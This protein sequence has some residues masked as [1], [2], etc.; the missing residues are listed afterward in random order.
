ML[1]LKPWC[2][3]RQRFSVFRKAL[4]TNAVANSHEKNN[5]IEGLCRQISIVHDVR[6]ASKAIE[7]LLSLPDGTSVAWSAQALPPRKSPAMVTLCGYA[8]D[9]FQ[10][11]KWTF[12][13]P[14]PRHEAAVW[15]L[16]RE[17]FRDKAAKLICYDIDNFTKHLG[18]RGIQAKG[19][20][21]D[22]QTMIRM[23]CLKKR[24]FDAYVQNILDKR[25]I[26]K[27]ETMFS[28]QQERPWETP[29][30][31]MRFRSDEWISP[32]CADAH[33]VFH[34]YQRMKKKMLKKGALSAEANNLFEAYE[35]FYAHVDMSLSTIGN[36]MLFL[37]EDSFADVLMRFEY[38]R[39]SQQSI[40]ESW[41]QKYC[42]QVSHVEMT[43]PMLRHLLFAP[44]QNKH[45]MTENIEPE[46]NFSARQKVFGGH[47]TTSTV[48]RSRAKKRN[49]SIKG[50]GLVAQK[51]T[52]NGVPSVSIP[53]L[54]ALHATLD[55]AEDAELK[56]AFCAIKGLLNGQAARL[57]AQNF[58]K[59]VGQSVDIDRQ[60][61]PRTKVDF[62]RGRLQTNV[63][64][65]VLELLRSRKDYEV[66]VLDF[67]NL[68]LCALADFSGCER[69]KKR[70]HFKDGV[71]AYLAKEFSKEVSNALFDGKCVL[72]GEGVTV[73]KA[74]PDKFQ[75]AKMLDKCMS[76]APRIEIVKKVMKCDQARA[77]QLVDGWFQVHPAVRS[78]CEQEE[79]RMRD[80]KVAETVR[81]RQ[82]ILKF[83][84]GKRSALAV[85]EG[86]TFAIEGSAGDFMMQSVLKLVESERI[87]A[88]AWQV[89]LADGDRI[90]MHGPRWSAEEVA[91]AAL[92][93]LASSNEG[94]PILESA[95]H[96]LRM[97]RGENFRALGRIS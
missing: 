96:Q 85:N 7:A 27:R 38:D 53:A 54:Q 2:C 3:F 51:Y 60:V 49:V 18:S 10:N 64:T 44:Y 71:H 82:R 83:G 89:M 74:F 48:K 88:L 50:A 57:A 84:G 93:T 77:L 95:L 70:L 75:M 14:P 15:G 45:D 56:A 61:W 46:K 19:C 31:E 40:F 25:T 4:A 97:L 16:M 59:E 47:D 28:G 58:G 21:Y 92:E 73:E 66:L 41:A 39:T 12:I 37:D 67:E 33:A 24:G 86:M 42:E 43:S 65:S 22:V 9:A 34:I 94:G 78:W 52:S 79:G 68:S 87:N 17:Y 36:Q 80:R 30:K 29:S 8:G 5:D 91:H 11:G 26:G 76:K 32:A 69:L 6:T 72:K 1:S 90:V 35:K 63:S 62:D 81:G 13:C 23:S 20:L 55:S